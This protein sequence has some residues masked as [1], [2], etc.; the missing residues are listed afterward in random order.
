MSK[1]LILICVKIIPFILAL[2]VCS[3]IHYPNIL[4]QEEIDL[5]NT[6]C[7]ISIIGFVLLLSYEFKFCKYHR[8]Y[9]YAIIVYYLTYI[10]GIYNIVTYIFLQIYS[11]IMFSIIFILIGVSVYLHIKEK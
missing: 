4:R 9:L 10:V 8:L 3:V 5:I 7:N 1:R 2:K 11:P 6:L